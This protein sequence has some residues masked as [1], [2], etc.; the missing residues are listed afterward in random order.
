MIQQKKLIYNYRADKKKNK[1]LDTETLKELSLKKLPQY[2]Y[3]NNQ[4]FKECI[5][6]N[7]ENT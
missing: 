1:F 5:Y 2:V 6:N 7:K 4:K 3:L